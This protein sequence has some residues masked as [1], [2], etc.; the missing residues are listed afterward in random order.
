MDR[1]LLAKNKENNM[2]PVARY[3]CDMVQRGFNDNCYPD[4]WQTYVP[5]SLL[6]GEFKDNAGKKAASPK[7]F[8]TEV[9]KIFSIKIHKH[10]YYI[11][12][13]RILCFQFSD[14]GSC[15]AAFCNRFG[16]KQNYL[17]DSFNKENEDSNRNDPVE[18]DDETK[19]PE[20]LIRQRWLKSLTEKSWYLEFLPNTWR[21]SANPLKVSFTVD[22]S[23]N[24]APNTPVVP[25]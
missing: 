18:E 22:R 23:S 19:V 16:L 24:S 8:E 9:C 13:T 6:Y 4:R 11:P 15:K 1:V 20:E 17:D 14:F 21:N 5:C 2:D 7:Q 25:C 3:C 10:P 12:E